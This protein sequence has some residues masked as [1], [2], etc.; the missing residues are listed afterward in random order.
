MSRHY[1]D[2]ISSQAKWPTALDRE[3]DPG[4]AFRNG[5]N[6]FSLEEK[7]QEDVLRRGI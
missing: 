6:Q 1:T 2:L 4:K 5:S 3:T 7:H